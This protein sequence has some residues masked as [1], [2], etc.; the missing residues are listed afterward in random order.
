MKISIPSYR[1][2][3][4]SRAYESS[5]PIFLHFRTIWQGLSYWTGCTAGCV[6]V[7]DGSR[8]LCYV[9]GRRI[10]KATCI[11]LLLS[12]GNAKTHA[13][14]LRVDIAQQSHHTTDLSLLTFTKEQSVELLITW[15]P[16]CRGN[17]HCLLDAISKSQSPEQ[18]MLEQQIHL[19]VLV[20]QSCTSYIRNLMTIG[21]AVTAKFGERKHHVTVIW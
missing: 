4:V 10:H 12:C 20:L 9:W 2:I 16:A 17:L 19:E 1:L 15:R 13:S 3:T 11:Q 8:Q 18:W 5:W 7:C 21:S 6:H 14:P